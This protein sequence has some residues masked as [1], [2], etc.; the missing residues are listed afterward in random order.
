MRNNR[1]NYGHL[2]MSSKLR[3][4]KIMKELDFCAVHNLKFSQIKHEYIIVIQTTS[5]LLLMAH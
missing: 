3:N 1:M 2:K 4:Y 5:Y